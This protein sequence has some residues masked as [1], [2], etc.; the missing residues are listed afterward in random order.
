MYA[1]A[2]ACLQNAISSN[3]DLFLQYKVSWELA[4][5]T[6]PRNTKQQTPNSC[7]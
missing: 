5:G 7:Q 3:E 4:S 6:F 1:A 2:D